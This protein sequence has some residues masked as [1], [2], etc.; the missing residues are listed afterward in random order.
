MRRRIPVY[1][2][3]GLIGLAAFL[4]YAVWAFHAASKVGS[5]WAGLNS[6]WPYLLAGVLTFACVLGAFVWLAFFSERRGYDDRVR[7]P[8]R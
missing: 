2:S 7:M 6:A 8:K 1:V 5:G 3:I 4:A